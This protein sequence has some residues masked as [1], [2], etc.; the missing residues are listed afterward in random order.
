MFRLAL[1][2][3][4]FA[5]AQAAPQTATPAPVIPKASVIEADSARALLSA[6]RIYVESFGEDSINKT[7]QAMVIDAI[8]G[9]KRFIITENK[10]K[11]DL[12]LKGSSLEKT[13]QEMHSLDSA[14]T[15]AGASGGGSSQVSGHANSAGAVVSGSS[16][17]GFIAR[18]LGI[19]DSE[20]SIETVNDARA[21][22]RLISKDGD[23]V[24]STTQESKGAKYKGA[25][26]DVADK[27]VKQLMRDLSK[28]E[29]PTTGQK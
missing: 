13:T 21:S 29:G 16:H 4:A 11:A 27:I 10:D 19:A 23:M 28:L 8:G 25:I 7:L 20:S 12:V 9:S 22:V 3:L 17:G 24:W 2:P 14:T 15:V 6:K 26:A 1:L 5:F 18:K